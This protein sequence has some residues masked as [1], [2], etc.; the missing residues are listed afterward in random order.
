MFGILFASKL[1]E[2]LFPDNVRTARDGIEFEAVKLSISLFLQTKL[3]KFENS[4][5]FTEPLNFGVDVPQSIA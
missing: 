2:S 5:I 1:P 3:F 4:V